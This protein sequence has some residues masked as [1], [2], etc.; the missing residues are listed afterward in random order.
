MAAWDDYQEEVASFFRGIG[1]E[2]ATNV[3]VEGVR[4]SH[5]IDVVVKSKH[6]GFDMLWIVECKNWNK[7]VSKLHVLALREIVSDIGADRGLLMA[8]NGFQ[9]GAREAAELTNVKL[10]S[11]SE[12]TD[13]A[14]YAL[15][16]ASLRALQDRV[17]ICRSRYW[18]LRKDFRIGQGLRPPV[19]LAGYSGNFVIE[20]AE[21]ALSEAFKGRFPPALEGAL[22]P[23]RAR[24]A[25]TATSPAELYEEVE[26]MVAELEGLLDRAYV[27]LETEMNQIQND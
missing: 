21:A 10:T 27:V 17:D 12:V 14:G 2:A 8:E 23:L 18:D 20:I 26:P 5:D 16:M 22:P 19:G 4:T 9:S 24:A 3:P 1:L 11:L 7:P 13:S 15:G 25:F 6:V